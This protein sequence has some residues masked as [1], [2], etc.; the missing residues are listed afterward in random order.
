[1]YNMKVE[2]IVNKESENKSINEIL[3]Q[4]LDFSNRLLAKVIRKKCVYLK[5]HGLMNSKDKS[6]Y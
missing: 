1:M 5:V 3:M 6:L 4:Q 2:Y